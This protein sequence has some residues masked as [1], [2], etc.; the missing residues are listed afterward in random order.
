MGIETLIPDIY[1]LF[2]KPH[3]PSEENIQTF[4]HSVASI[5][6]DRL[7]EQQ[8]SY[9]RPSN[10]GQPCE[11]KLWY[12]INTPS[13]AE[14]IPLKARFKFL[15]GDLIEALVLFLAAEA[16]HTVE[17]CQT[18][19]SIAEVKGRRD[20]IIDG[21]LVDVKSANTR[22]FEKFEKQTLGQGDD[23]FGYTDQLDFYRE[24]SKDDP[25]V[26]VKDKAAFLA[27]DKELGSMV[28]D[29]HE[30]K[31]IDWE[32]RISSKREMLRLPEPP[33]RCFSDVPEGKSGN[34]RL[35]VPCTYCP[36]KKKCWPGLRTFL[37]SNGPMYL[38]KVEKEPKVMDIS[39]ARIAA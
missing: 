7:Q 39:D 22:S 1:K 15:Y 33:G 20:A 28:L 30:A 10:I 29:I 6:G 38:T 3:P 5:M 17:G 14:P 26:V 34:R 12:T 9:L 24:A 27:V 32:A 4:A 18:S 11:R 2:D 36:F 23:P 16:G 8:E 13:E 19:V 35:T 21:V 37:Y 25:S 31:G